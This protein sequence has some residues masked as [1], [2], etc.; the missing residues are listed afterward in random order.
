MSFVFR[1]IQYT[2]FTLK[3]VRA[4]ATELKA[5][6]KKSKWILPYQSA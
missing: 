5:E 2:T 3:K 6:V 1:D 4:K